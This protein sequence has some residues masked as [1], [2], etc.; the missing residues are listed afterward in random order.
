MMPTPA[1][2]ARIATC[3][4]QWRSGQKRPQKSGR[5][6]AG[7]TDGTDGTVGA[8]ADDMVDSWVGL[9]EGVC[10]PVAA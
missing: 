1:A 4:P 3:G 2:A 5:G 9:D 8:T 7:G 10:R 6:A